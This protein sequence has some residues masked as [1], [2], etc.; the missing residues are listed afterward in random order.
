MRGEQA[1][2]QSLSLFA[3][4]S[5]ILA[6]GLVM[7]GSATAPIAAEKF[8][9]A[10]HFLIDRFCWDL[11]RVHFCLLDFVRC[12]SHGGKSHGS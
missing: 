9:N 8:G 12:R 2:G 11:F 7:L 3:I 10:Y 4:V 1:E 6:F 5:I